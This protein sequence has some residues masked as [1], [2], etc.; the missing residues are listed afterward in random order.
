MIYKL[1]DNNLLVIHSKNIYY[2]QKLRNSERIL[3]VENSFSGCHRKKLLINEDRIFAIDN[4]NNFRFWPTISIPK[5]LT[6]NF[7]SF[8][9]FSWILR[10]LLNAFFLIEL[11]YLSLPWLYCFKLYCPYLFVTLLLKL[12]VYKLYPEQVLYRFCIFLSFSKSSLI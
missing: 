2:L 8:N 4:N 1:G 5:P 9:V 6:D 12:K 3:I 10:C 7:W 11:V